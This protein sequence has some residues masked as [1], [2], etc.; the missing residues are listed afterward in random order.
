VKRPETCE[1]YG[2]KRDVKDLRDAHSMR[3]V[4]GSERCERRD[5]H[6]RCERNVK[7]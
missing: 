2:R 6:K 4:T 7:I 1:I 5:R 3:D